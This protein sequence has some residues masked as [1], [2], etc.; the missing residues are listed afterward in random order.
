[1]DHILAKEYFTMLCEK[2]TTGIVTNFILSEIYT[3]TMMKIRKRVAIEF[4]SS[5][6]DSLEIE[7]VTQTDEDRAW[8]ILLNYKDQDFS[9]VDATS[10]AVMERLSIT[11]AFAFDDH[12]SWFPSIKRVPE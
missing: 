10:F 2:R 1:M 9:Y 7:R 6:R 3:L 8:E 5:L 12:F 4:I 11:H